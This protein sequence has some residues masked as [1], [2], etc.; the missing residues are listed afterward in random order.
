VVL[1]TNGLQYQDASTGKC[2]H[3]QISKIGEDFDM[4]GRLL[5]LVGV[6]DAGFSCAAIYDTFDFVSC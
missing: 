6:L 2:R 1:G 3:T 4:N 5:K